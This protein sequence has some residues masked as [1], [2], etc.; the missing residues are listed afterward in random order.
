MMNIVRDVLDANVVDRNGREMGRVDGIVIEH[1]DG[2]PRITTLLIGPA[3]LGSRLHPTL[4][5]LMT[6]L[7]ALLGVERNGPSRISV[8]DVEEA[9]R[10]IR[11]HLSLG[12]TTVA[13]FEQRLRRWIVKLPGSQ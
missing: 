7:E 10:K 4:G 12:E 1:D 9:D 3:A 2:P 13:A 8:R 11:V 5:R 6:R